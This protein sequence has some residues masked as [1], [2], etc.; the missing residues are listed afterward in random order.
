MRHGL[1]KLL[2][3]EAV[4]VIPSDV[5]GSAFAEARQRRSAVG[6]AITRKRPDRLCDLCALC[7]KPPG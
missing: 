4:F 3:P 5:E 2:L 1:G 7:E 6:T